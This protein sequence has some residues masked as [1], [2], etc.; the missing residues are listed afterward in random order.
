MPISKS[1]RL[2]YMQHYARKR[3]KSIGNWI[4]CAEN[5]ANWK[6]VR[7]GRIYLW[8]RSSTETGLGV[9][10]YGKTCAFQSVQNSETRVY[11][12]NQSASHLK[13]KNKKVSV[14][15]FSTGKSRTQDPRCTF[16]F[17]AQSHCIEIGRPGLVQFGISLSLSRVSPFF[18]LLLPIPFEDGE[19]EE[20]EDLMIESGK[21]RHGSREGNSPILL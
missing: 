6:C 18:F 11:V 21:V 9:G 7:R 19:G 16:G 10:G 14:P 2:P 4:C 17:S 13:P 1:I 8:L 3:E 20:E 5:V 15:L 12:A